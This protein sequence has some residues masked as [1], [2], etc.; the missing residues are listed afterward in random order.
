[1]GW[2]GKKSP[3][4]CRAGAEC[5]VDDDEGAVAARVPNSTQFVIANNGTIHHTIDF[6]I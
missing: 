2:R 3:A 4:Y 6:H 5:N 1:M